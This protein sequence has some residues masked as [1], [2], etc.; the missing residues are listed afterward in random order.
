MHF[1]PLLQLFWMLQLDNIFQTNSYIIL[2]RI[3]LQEERKFQQQICHL[4][5]LNSVFEVY[6]FF[7]KTVLEF[8]RL[9]VIR[10]KFLANETFDGLSLLF[11]SLVEQNNQHFS[12]PLPNI[13]LYLKLFAYFRKKAFS[14]LQHCTPG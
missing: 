12:P 7:S 9:W 14:C 3:K 6:Y 1:L 8:L 4:V 5:S 13:H 10:C 2:Q 11:L